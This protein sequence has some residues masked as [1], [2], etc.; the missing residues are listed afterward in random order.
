[1]RVIIKLHEILDIQDSCLKH[2][3]IVLDLKYTWRKIRGSET[4]ERALPDLKEKSVWVNAGMPASPDFY[5]I[6]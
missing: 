3:V 4:R 1:M 2:F 6:P 5:I